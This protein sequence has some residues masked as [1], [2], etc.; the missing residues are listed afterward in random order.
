MD[1]W[2]QAWLTY[3]P[4]R[5]YEDRKYFMTVYTEEEDICVK[6][7]IEEIKLAAQSLFGFSVSMAEKKELAGIVLEKSA[8]VNTGTEGYTIHGNENQIVICAEDAKGLLYGTFRLI[9]KA[10]SGEKIHMLCLS[11]K[12]ENPFRMLNLWDNIDGTIERGYAGNSFLYEKGEICITKR[13]CDFARLLCS[14]G[15]NSIAVNN[16]NVRDG[17]EWLITDRHYDKLR[18]MSEI[19]R[20][21]GISMFLCIDFAAPITIDGMATSDPLNEKVQRWWQE[22]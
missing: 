18:S 8:A 11:E 20:A 14:V 22:K 6:S 16:V 10:A 2:E 9:L 4:A 21:Y 1:N 17:A 13:L 19:F 5:E 7:A 3:K 15:I 12:P